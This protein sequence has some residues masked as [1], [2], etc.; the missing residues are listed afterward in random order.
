MAHEASPAFASDSRS[1]P[2]S[3]LLQL[4]AATPTAH[5]N[6]S[7]TYTDKKANS[8]TASDSR[9]PSVLEASGG[10][11]HDEGRFAGIDRKKLLRRVDYRLLPYTL[12]CYMIVKSRYFIFP[13]ERPFPYPLSFLRTV[14]LDLNNINNAYV[15]LHVSPA[16]LREY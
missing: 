12:L 15:C 13:R 14:R 4:R 7:D 1:F 2:L 3:L 6:M 9:S 5:N 16:F 11:G 8:D 10:L